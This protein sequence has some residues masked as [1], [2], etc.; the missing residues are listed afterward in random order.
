MEG[1]LPIWFVEPPTEI[2]S[3]WKAVHKEANVLD[4]WYCMCKSDG[5]L[6]S[7]VIFHYLRCG[8]KFLVCLVS[9]WRGGR[10]NGQLE[11]RMCMKAKN[12]GLAACHK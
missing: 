11:V 7:E 8:V 12:E 2:A 3:L 4:T 10:G 5:E 1:Y 9:K 6:I